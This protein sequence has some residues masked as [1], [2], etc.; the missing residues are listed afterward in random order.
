MWYVKDEFTDKIYF[1]SNDVRKSQAFVNRYN[2]SFKFSSQRMFR[3]VISDFSGLILFWE[4]KIDVNDFCKS[5]GLF[6]STK[7]S[8]PLSVKDY[9]KRHLV[10]LKRKFDLICKLC[11]KYHLWSYTQ[12]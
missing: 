9:H 8:H 11:K 4:S 1:K 6:S 12:L 5:D 3:F 10:Y 7:Y 2:H